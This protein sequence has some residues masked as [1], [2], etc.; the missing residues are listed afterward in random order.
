MPASSEVIICEFEMIQ[1]LK[2]NFFFFILKMLIVICSVRL[3]SVNSELC[4]LET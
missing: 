1:F 2:Y 4:G 3:F